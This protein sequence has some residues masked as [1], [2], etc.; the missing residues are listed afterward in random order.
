MPGN[1]GITQI[2]DRESRNG[3]FCLIPVGPK[4]KAGNLKDSSFQVQGPRCWNALP[5]YIRNLNCEDFLE[6]KKEV[7]CYLGSLPDIPRI[8]RSTLVKNALYTIFI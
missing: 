1:C 2:S 3:L 5:A 8:G 7:D 6:F 4:S